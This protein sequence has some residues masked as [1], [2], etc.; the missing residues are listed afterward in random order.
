MRST[1]KPDLSIVIPAL[2]ESKRIAKTLDKLALF[3]KNNKLIKSLIVEVIIV[4]ADC[5][6][7]SHKI[8]QSKAEL[9]DNFIFM[10]AGPVAGK[11]RDVRLGMLK[12]RGKAVIFMDADLATPLKYLPIFYESYLSGNDVVVATR[13]LK[14]H[15]P[16]RLRRSLSIAGNILYR[17][18]GGVWIED[19]Q[20]GFKLFSS[21]AAKS[22]FS[23]LTT[24]GW[25]FD[26]EV[27]TIAKINNFKIKSF[28]IDD[29]TSVP[30]GT[31]SDG[32]LASSLSSLQE[33]F[34]IFR[35][36]MIRRY[37]DK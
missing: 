19:S 31:F 8:I 9:F 16:E 34:K 17:I 1:S 29:W 25:G 2:N 21:R 5:I 15:H 26:M 10:K 14:K 4:S 37:Q 24:S 11:G 22:S 18:L 6:D 33:L 12:A 3:I 35:H 27:L 36:R 20:C 32:A 13:N 30:G 23:K 7:D 28:R